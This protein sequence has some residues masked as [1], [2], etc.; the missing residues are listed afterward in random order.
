MLKNP[1]PRKTKFFQERAILKKIKYYSRWYREMPMSDRITWKGK[2]V[3]TQAE[4]HS[5]VLMGLADEIIAGDIPAEKANE[6]TT[7]WCHAAI[8]RMKRRAA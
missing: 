2:W 8:E 6:L 5:A 1:I 4:I 7:V 3:K